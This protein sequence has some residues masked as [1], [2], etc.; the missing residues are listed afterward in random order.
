MVA[1]VCHAKMA[2]A[3][4]PD[5]PR[6]QPDES[7]NWGPEGDVAELTGRRVSATRITLTRFLRSPPHLLNDPRPSPGCQIQGKKTRQDAVSQGIMGLMGF[8]QMDVLVSSLFN[9]GP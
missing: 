6:F 1:T 5:W 3:I 2:V 9:P 8:I 7:A 4:L